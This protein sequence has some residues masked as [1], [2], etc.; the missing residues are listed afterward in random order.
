MV[1]EELVAPDGRI[2]G[3]DIV[4]RMYYVDPAGSGHYWA[5]GQLDSKNAGKTS[6]AAMFAP[7]RILQFGGNSNSAAVIDIRAG[8]RLSRSRSMSS[9]AGCTATILADG[10][11]LATGGSTV[12]NEMIGVNYKAEIWNPTTGQWTTAR[13]SR[14]APLSLDRTAAARCHRAGAGGGEPGPQFNDNVEIYYPPYLYDGSG[15]WAIRPVIDSAPH[16]DIGE[17]FVVNLRHA[18]S[19]CRP[20]Q[21]GVGHA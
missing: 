1:P 21:D 8:P 16:I 20:G 9:S 7:G 18:P 3:Y 17:T 11:V 5:A 19:A 4:G 6:A 14:G 13:G 10:K 15:G 2:F 12:S